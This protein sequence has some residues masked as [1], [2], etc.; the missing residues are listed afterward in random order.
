MT[1][2]LLWFD[3]RFAVYLMLL[4]YWWILLEVD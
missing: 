3:A 1:Y 2:V 4:T